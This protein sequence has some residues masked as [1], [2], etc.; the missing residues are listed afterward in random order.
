M[1]KVIDIS[2][3][4]VVEDKFLHVAEGK[5][6]K[7]DDR[8]N[9]VIKVNEMLNNAQTKNDAKMIDKV[10]SLTLGEKAFREIEKMDLS[11]SAY[12]DLFIGIMAAISD[13]KFEDMEKS[14]RE[15]I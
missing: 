7:V 9:T 10:I 12:Q 2:S 8:K 5:D 15:S 3:K 1:S 11:F 6:Y 4:L 14:F 13:K